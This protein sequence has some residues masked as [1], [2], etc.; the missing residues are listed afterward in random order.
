M[1]E[2]KF[3]RVFGTLAGFARGGFLAGSGFL[4]LPA[5]KTTFFWAFR[6]KFSLIVVI[7]DKKINVYVG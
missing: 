6:K 1:I 4:P 3:Q 5:K 7:F 2:K